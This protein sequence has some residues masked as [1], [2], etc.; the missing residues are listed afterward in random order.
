MII[1]TS[2]PSTPKVWLRSFFSDKYTEYI[3]GLDG[4]VREMD[5]GTMPPGGVISG[6]GTYAG[7]P[8]DSFY[9]MADRAREY[10]WVQVLVPEFFTS[11]VFT[12]F[13]SGA[14]DE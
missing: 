14:M 5:R 12:N 8:R 1:Q 7:L 11:Q 2:P 6:N 4:A 3:P 10:D 9:G 13:A